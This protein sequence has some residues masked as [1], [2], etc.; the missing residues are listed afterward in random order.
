M[1]RTS[2]PNLAQ[3]PETRIDSTARAISTLNEMEALPLWFNNGVINSVAS[4]KP[5]DLPDYE[6]L[7]GGERWTLI[8][9][10][11]G[12]KDGHVGLELRRSNSRQ[13]VLLTLARS[14]EYLPIRFRTI[15]HH[16]ATIDINVT[17]ALRDGLPF[18][19]KWAATF[20]SSSGKLARHV[21][22]QLVDCK[23]NKPIEFPAMPAR[24]VRQKGQ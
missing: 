18:A 6:R 3:E 21:E 2:Y 9:K 22:L 20:F 5:L 15:V 14:A 7:A 17:Y 23:I 1:V 8:A 12:A 19:D 13:R 11:E 4:A 10:H 24:D 16:K